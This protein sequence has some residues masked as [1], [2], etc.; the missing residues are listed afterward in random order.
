[1]AALPPPQPPL[2]SGAEGARAPTLPQG[3][4]KGT[5]AHMVILAT[6][7]LAQSSLGS[8]AGPS[9]GHHSCE[10]GQRTPPWKHEEG[11]VVPA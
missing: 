3:A 9:Q 8:R 7:G 10:Q 6:A 1:M 2:P 4:H 11:G 5:S